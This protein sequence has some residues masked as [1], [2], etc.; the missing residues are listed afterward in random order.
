LAKAARDLVE[1]LSSSGLTMACAESCTGGLAA[2]AL[3][4]VPGASEVLWGGFV[5]YSNDC[6]ARILGVSLATLARFGAVSRETAREMAS[7][8]L[9][10][11]GA[12]IAFSVTGVAGPD[13]GT[14][15][16][17]VGLVWFAWKAAEGTSIEESIVFEGN[18]DSIRTAAAVRALRGTYD[19]AA[20]LSATAVDS[21]D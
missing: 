9:T 13:G 2:A 16:T 20:S 12:D 5:A 3:A 14:P 17:P 18:R 7:G 21:A 6:K 4:G 15:D 11:S 19:L 1:I 10:A 8:A